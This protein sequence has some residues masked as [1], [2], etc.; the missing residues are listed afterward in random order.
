MQKQQELMGKFKTNALLHPS[1]A[2]RLVLK[3]IFFLSFLIGRLVNLTLDLSRWQCGIS[4]WR[5]AKSAT[6]GQ[7]FPLGSMECHTRPLRRSNS[8]III[9]TYF[10]QYTVGSTFVGR[11]EKKRHGLQC[12][13]PMW[14]LCIRHW[15]LLRQAND[16]YDR[17][18]QDAMA[19]GDGTVLKPLEMKQKLAGYELN[20]LWVHI[21]RHLS[22]WLLRI[23]EEMHIRRTRVCLDAH[24]ALIKSSLS[25][26]LERILCSY[27]N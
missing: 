20:L 24:W 22:M 7:T 18:K 14:N 8:Y 25:S 15:L 11:Y 6:L 12:N 3:S 17:S 9:F 21:F 10:I 16:D 5:T 23:R 1:P 26:S 4:G 13:L 27:L 2:H 19:G